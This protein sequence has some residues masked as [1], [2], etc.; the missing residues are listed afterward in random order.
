MAAPGADTAGC[1]A[2]GADPRP[3]LPGRRVGYVVRTSSSE[4]MGMNSGLWVGGGIIWLILLAF[5]IRG[6]TRGHWVM[7]LVGI[8]IPIFWLIGGLV[9][10]RR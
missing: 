4:G 9:P 8:V 5:G 7:F 2:D 10:A 3:L 6:L 1:P